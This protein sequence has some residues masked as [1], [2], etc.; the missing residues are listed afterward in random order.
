[1]KKE[2][3]NSTLWISHLSTNNQ[4]VIKKDYTPPKLEVLFVEM[5]QGITVESAAV[6]PVIIGGNTDSV[7]TDWEGSTDTS[8]DS[9]F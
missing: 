2:N 1:M 7:A 3:S 5:E 8:I 4:R 6:L 9:P